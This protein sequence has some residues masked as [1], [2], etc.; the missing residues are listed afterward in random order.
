MARST[1]ESILTAAAEL[2]RHRGYAAVGMKD[3]VTAS[4]S[5]IG[6]LYHHFPGGKLQIAREALVNAGAAYGLLIP[7]LVDPFEDLG[8][9]I[10][11][12]FAQAAQDMAATGFANMCPVASVAAEIADTVPELRE[13]TAGIFT[14]WLDGG[15]TYFVSRGLEPEAARELAVALIGSLEGAF[16]LARTLRDTESL[17][18]AGR[19]LASRYR[20][21]RLTTAQPRPLED[22]TSSPS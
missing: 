17:L 3:V 4:G 14:G 7:T 16:V 21:V 11:S 13:T 6:S 15:T 2:M 9:A 5:P 22:R 12:S 8:A 19:V 20:G 1:R 10:E 18:I